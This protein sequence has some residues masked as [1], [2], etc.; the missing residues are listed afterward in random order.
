[1][2]TQQIITIPT[3]NVNIEID[4]FKT[5]FHILNTPPTYKCIHFKTTS[6]CPRSIAGVLG[7]LHQRVA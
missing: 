4:L 5:T 3:F 2:I 6:V 7:K 1:M